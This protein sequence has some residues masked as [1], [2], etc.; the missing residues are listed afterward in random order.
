MR[1]KLLGLTYVT[2]LQTTCDGHNCDFTYDEMETQVPLI[3]MKSLENDKIYTLKLTVDEGECGSG[4]CLATFMDYE[5][6]KVSQME[7]CEYLPLDDA[8]IE[9]SGGCENFDCSY[10]EFSKYGGDE[11]YP[12]GY[13]SVIDNMWSEKS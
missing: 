10:F 12:S 7:I 3:Y 11:Y 4:W 6:N 5:L 1:Y 8:T 9:F 13:Y 2:Y